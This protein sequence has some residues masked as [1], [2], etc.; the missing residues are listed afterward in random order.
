MGVWNSKPGRR[1]GRTAF[2]G[3]LAAIGCGEAPPPPAPPPAQVRVSEVVIRNVPLS[4]EWVGETLGQSDVDI[5]ARVPG[6]LEEI[7]F[8]EGSIVSKGQ[9]LYTI[10]D[11]E[12]LQEVT[13]SEADLAAARTLLANAES[14]V[15]RYRPLA[16]MKAISERDLDNA[17][18]REEAAA[19]EVSAAEARVRLAKINLSYAE[20]HAPIHGLIGMTRAQIG[21]FVGGYG[22][23][24]LNTVSTIDPIHVRFSIT[25]QEYLQLARMYPEIGDPEQLAALR[26]KRRSDAERLELILADGS[27]HTHRGRAVTVGREIDPMTGT[28]AVEAAF[29]NPDRVLRPG[30]YGKVRAVFEVRENA[31]LV[32]QRAVQELQGQFL[33]WV[34]GDDS[35][36]TSRYVEPG[37][38]ADDLWIIDEGLEPGLRVVVEGV[39]RLRKG[40]KVSVQPYSGAAGQG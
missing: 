7:H 30:Q 15:R 14:D 5:R 34:V 32:P 39:Q 17:V 37:P 22:G 9:L 10:D 20:I 29:P 8:M 1:V 6:F 4:K 12:L 18:A 25:E 40:A 27:L 38:R 11:S 21:D 31:V 3:L 19:S 28:L 26:K 16:E 13:A 33:V 36:V 2:A 23:S 24:V 35:T